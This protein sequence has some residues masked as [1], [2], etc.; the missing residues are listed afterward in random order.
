[1]G[2]I[3]LLPI[4]IRISGI[5]EGCLLL[6]FTLI[7]GCTIGPV[8]YALVSEFSST[9]LKSK[10]INVARA[11]YNLFG[12]FTSIVMPYML[13]SEAWNWGPKSAWFWAAFCLLCLVWVYFRLPEPNGHTYAEMDWLFRNK[14]SARKFSKTECPAFETDEGE[15]KTEGVV[16]MIGTKE[17]VVSL[18]EGGETSPL[19]EIVAN[20]VAE[21]QS[22]SQGSSTLVKD[23]GQLQPKALAVQTEAH[24]GPMSK[25]ATSKAADEIERASAKRTNSMAESPSSR[26]KGGSRP[27]C[28]LM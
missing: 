16:V 22:T 7:Y 6:L 19:Q 9:R 12:V 15:A 18:P 26:T 24:S 20:P 25:H 13:N 17:T 5:V 27:V 3:A 4:P 23:E 11:T 14:I 28:S 10:T 21:T 8:T 1:M 2:I